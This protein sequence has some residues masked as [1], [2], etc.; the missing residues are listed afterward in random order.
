MYGSQDILIIGDSFCGQRHK[1]G[2]WPW[3]LHLILT[4]QP[5]TPRGKGFPGASWWSSRRCLLKELSIRVPRLLILCHTNQYRL[6]NDHDLGIGQGQAENHHIFVPDE[7]AHVY[8][9]DIQAAA[10]SYYRHLFSRNYWI[11]AAR[12]WFQE[13]EDLIRQHQIPQV[14]HM[15]SY[16]SIYDFQTGMVL[17]NSLFDRVIPGINH[18]NHYG[19]EHNIQIAKSLHN[20]LTNYQEG[21]RFVI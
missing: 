5:G 19:Y 8:S 2:D 3:E 16:E 14:L 21:S 6:P 17:Q 9:D 13:L 7:A 1:T 4:G 11:W 10:S 20:T 12:S 18:S 15:C